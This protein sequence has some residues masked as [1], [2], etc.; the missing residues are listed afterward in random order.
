[1]GGEQ[2]AVKVLVTG[3]GG[4]L[5]LAIVRE[6]LA[7]GHAP[8][9]FSRSSHPELDELD[10]PSMRG[11]LDNEAAVFDAIEGHDAAIHCAAK[12]GV[13]GRRDDYVRANVNGTRHVVEA[14][15]RHGVQRL[16]FTSSPSVCF[17]G[18]DHVRAKNDLPYPRRYLCHY[19][20]TKAMGERTV[21]RSNGKSGLATCAIR[22]HLIFGPGDPHLIPRL[23][24]RGRKKRLAIIGD[25]DNE[26][27]LTFVENAAA[28]HVDALEAFDAHGPDS[29]HAGRAYFLGQEEPVKLW[30]WVA[31]LFERLDVPRV[32]R[33]IPHSL[34]YAGGAVC[35]LLW[36]LTGMKN[37][38]PMT[39]FVASQLATS[40]S[41]D[42]EPAR[43]DFGYHERVGL[44]DATDRTIAALTPRR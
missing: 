2:G 24:D 12:A 42:L 44:A 4:F 17:D 22:P 33:R 31:R 35:E 41:Y 32:R 39:R 38:P 18:N 16:V 19:P 10:V 15:F 43:R 14:C 1:M 34:A 6:L 3:G 21:L 30:E 25:G 36:N 40:H 26:V 9:S 13:W 29:D 23:V 11:D 27:S 28:A 37:E 8:T 5:G 7:R 20:E